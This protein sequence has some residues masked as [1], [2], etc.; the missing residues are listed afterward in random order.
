ME[1]VT[2]IYRL[3]FYREPGRRLPGCVSAARPGSP[4]DDDLRTGLAVFYVDV[5]Q[6]DDLAERACCPLNCYFTHD[7]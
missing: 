2:S 3:S 5:G 6:G 1:L 7:T 4:E